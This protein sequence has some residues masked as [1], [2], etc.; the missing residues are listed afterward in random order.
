MGVSVEPARRYPQRLAA[1]RAGF[2]GDLA[3]ARR[4]LTDE[5]PT[6]RVRALGALA[7]IGALD[8]PTHRA[9]LAD[10]APSVRR[11]AVQ[12]ALTLD[13]VP[14]LIDQLGDVD[15]SVVRVA[16]ETI[17]ETNVGPAA[18]QELIRIAVN[19][20]DALCRES[21]VAALG[22]SGAPEGIDTVLN[23]CSD[24]VAVRRRAVLMLAAWD[25][26]R[27]DAMLD[28]LSADRDRQVRQAAIDLLA[29]D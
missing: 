3:T 25:D 26:P 8:Q 29:I 24:V 23:A 6:T 12:L 5:D 22:A 11:R 27:C 17:G 21:A 18:V 15:P 28:H 16:C 20:D 9:A 1:A 10:P 13:P 4:L 7:R 2:S 19:H 14:D